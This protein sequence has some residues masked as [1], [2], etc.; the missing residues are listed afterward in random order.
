MNAGKQYFYTTKH[1]QVALTPTVYIRTNNGITIVSGGLLSHSLGLCSYDSFTD[2]DID[3]NIWW[4]GR[5]E[6]NQGIGCFGYLTVMLPTTK[7]I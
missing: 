5:R 2:V 7:V 3:S 4:K 6:M 1:N